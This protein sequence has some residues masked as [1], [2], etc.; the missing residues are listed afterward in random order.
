[1]AGLGPPI[2]PVVEDLVDL[3][4]MGALKLLAELYIARVRL[5]H[6]G[7]PRN[8]RRLDVDVGGD[9]DETRDLLRPAGGEVEG[10]RAAVAVAQKGSLPDRG[11]CHKLDEI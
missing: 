10:H 7:E 6:G 5:P 8:H 11:G 4:A 9:R 2:V 1:M 3:L